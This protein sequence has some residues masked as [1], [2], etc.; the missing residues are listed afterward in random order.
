LIAKFAIKY[1]EL[2]RDKTISGNFR[3]YGDVD[4]LTASLAILSNITLIGQD[5]WMF[6]AYDTI[7][8]NLYFMPDILQGGLAAAGPSVKPGWS[9]L[10]L[11]QGWSIGVEMWF[12]MLAP[13]LLTRS[14][15]VLLIFFACSFLIRIGLGEGAGWSEGPWKYRFFPVN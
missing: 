8:Q 3:G 2:N 9:M 4:I 6:L 11:Q 5:L 15:K 12:Y 7:G 10:M 13:F 14:I 1:P